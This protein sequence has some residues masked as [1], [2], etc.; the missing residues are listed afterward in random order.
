MNKLK[1]Y[2]LLFSVF[3][4]KNI[5]S[6]D[7][8]RIDEAI[9]HNEERAIRL[10]LN[11]DKA[12]SITDD[13]LKIKY[14]SELTIQSNNGS[15][16]PTQLSKL[17]NLYSLTLIDY[18]ITKEEIDYLYHFK[19][20]QVLILENVTFEIPVNWLHRTLNYLS[21]VIIKGKTGNIITEDFF[22]LNELE[23]LVVKNVKVDFLLSNIGKLTDLKYLKLNNNIITSLKSGFIRL[24]KLE[25]LD[26]KNNLFTQ[27][28]QELN[29]LE[30]LN[31]L[32]LSNCKVKSLNSSIS[33]LANLETLR[34][35]NNVIDSIKDKS[36]LCN[37][38]NLKE[39][40]LSNN[41]LTFNEL[42]EFPCTPY[43]F[44]IKGNRLSKNERLKILNKHQFQYADIPS[45]DV[46]FHEEQLA[47]DEYKATVKRENTPRLYV[48]KLYELAQNDTKDKIPIDFRKYYEEIGNDKTRDY[49]LF[50]IKDEFKKDQ[51]NLYGFADSNHNLILPPIFHDYQRI[52]GT[53]NFIL[54]F[55]NHQ[56][57]YNIAKRKWVL[58]I[59]CSD[60]NLRNNR[61]TYKQN[62]FYGLMV[63]TVNVLAPVY[64]YIEPFWTSYDKDRFYSIS[65]K[66]NRTLYD[67]DA[68]KLLPIKYN[69][70]NKK[71]P[72]IIFKSQNKGNI[73]NQITNKFIFKNPVQEIVYTSKSMSSIIVKIDNELFLMDTLGQKIIESPIKQLNKSHNVFVTSEGGILYNNKLNELEKLKNYTFEKSLDYQSFG[74]LSV[75]ASLNNRFGVIQFKAY[76]IY[77]DKIQFEFEDIKSVNDI[78]FILQKQGKY[79]L[80]EFKRGNE[81]QILEYEYDQIEVIH[82]GGSDQIIYKLRQGNKF[83][84]AINN[85]DLLY[86][87]C[88]ADSVVVLPTMTNFTNF[89]K[90]KKDGIWQIIMF[91]FNQSQKKHEFRKIGDGY[92]SI[93]GIYFTEILVEEDALYNLKTNQLVHDSIKYEDYQVKIQN[94]IK[95][96]QKTLS[97]E[98]LEFDKIIS[99]NYGDDR[100][101]VVKDGKWG[102]YS[103]FGTKQKMLLPIIYDSIDVLNQYVLIESDRKY[104]LLYHDFW[105]KTLDSIV[106]KIKY[107]HI[108]IEKINQS[109]FSF[110][111]KGKKTFLYDLSKN[112]QLY[113]TKSSLGIIEDISNSMIFIEVENNNKYALFSKDGVILTD[114][115]FDDILM[116]QEGLLI[117]KVKGKIGIYNISEKEFIINPMYD[118]LLQL[119]AGIKQCLGVSDDR[120]DFIEMDK[121]EIEFRFNSN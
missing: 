111:T 81:K 28:P 35:E 8:Y 68:K 107:D 43:E 92:K 110:L 46:S 89:F 54:K 87:T 5:F 44:I 65:L 70:V 117:V 106:L 64:D 37:L 26:L 101:I 77:F 113:K 100:K 83:N 19:N 72:F 9:N 48:Y 84:L 102:L 59:S 4:A 18:V 23:N 115:I 97:E 67:Y 36:I 75:I 119:Y 51:F 90:V 33:R 55:Y 41:Q 14:L 57:I 1:L 91:S 3:F 21:T 86:E 58:P 20:L 13:I 60:I 10:Y 103:I 45:E 53:P 88:I 112:E 47:F 79:G 105:K 120:I 12:D 114:Y 39:L 121:G 93:Y 15:K 98:H 6:Q 66:G 80:L 22:E 109:Y 32:N 116:M 24:Q 7:Y 94:Y 42:R 31:Y 11:S 2:I 16:L 62:G 17:N 118:E 76:G 40:D 74:S 96:S 29:Y 78:L 49:F 73:Y 52:K 30:K 38:K 99:F 95:E 27:L 82:R 61:I 34:L 69:Y 104:G 56:G 63:D 108:K 71:G 50:K 25:S 85:G